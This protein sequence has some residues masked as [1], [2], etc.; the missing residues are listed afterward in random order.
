MT[1]DEYTAPSLEEAYTLHLVRVKKICLN[2]LHDRDAADDMAQDVFVH[3][4]TRLHLFRGES[5]FTTWLH[6]VT[7]NRC[8]MK[9]RKDKAGR[10]ESLDGMLEEATTEGGKVSA[11]DLYK[12]LAIHDG[13]L[14]SCG[15]RKELLAALAALPVRFRTTI[16]LCDLQGYPIQEVAE[17][18][19]VSLGCV[20]SYLHRGRRR[21]AIS[22]GAAPTPLIRSERTMNEALDDLA[23]YL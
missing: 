23:K 11:K 4:S 13:D 15:E 6:R 3:L 2:I 8:L 21:L 17:L 9:I 18:L 7:I 1:T 14:E 20:K 22:L 16:E 19:D 12:A 10:T 5:K